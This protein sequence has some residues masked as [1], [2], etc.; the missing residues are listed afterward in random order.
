MYDN[1]VLITG[2]KGFIGSHL[3]SLYE[4]RGYEVLRVDKVDGKFP[5]DTNGDI[6]VFDGAGNRYPI[7]RLDRVETVIHLGATCGVD[8]VMG[9]PYAALANNVAIDRLIQDT[10]KGIPTIYASTSE[11]VD[12]DCN[13]PSKA[14]DQYRNL[15]ICNPRD[16]YS[17]GKMVGEQSF[18]Y[19]NDKNKVVRFFNVTGLGQSNRMVIPAM[20]ESA[21]T[22]NKIFVNG[23][24]D[25]IRSYIYINTVIEAIWA[26]H[27][28]HKRIVNDPID[29][30]EHIGN[31][32]NKISAID[33]AMLVCFTVWKATDN[34]PEIVHRYDDDSVAK[35]NIR[36][37]VPEISEWMEHVLSV[38]PKYDV[39]SIVTKLVDDA[40]V[41]RTS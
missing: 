2:Y 5:I 28:N 32:H 12:S 40:V 38:L 10:F 26:V 15:H 11:V 3:V 36:Y 1:V 27:H 21:M 33:L 13:V 29:R 23:D 31:P 17:A 14:D 4:S 9:D 19:A 39:E 6:I 20:I 16:V 30:I 22:H 35:S 18:L 41:R 34:I 8:A 37:R 7:S 24:G 25:D